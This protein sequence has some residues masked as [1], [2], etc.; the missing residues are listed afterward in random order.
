MPEPDVT[1]AGTASPKA[2]ATAK[3]APDAAAE[4]AAQ[5]AA[6]VAQ[7]AAKAAAEATAKAQADTALAKAIA[8]GVAH[9]L[10]QQQPGKDRPLGRTVATVEQLLEAKYAVNADGTP[11][12]PQQQL[13][14]DREIQ[15]RHQEDLLAAAQAGRMGAMGLAGISAQYPEMADVTSP[16]YRTVGTIIQ[17]DPAQL[18][19]ELLLIATKAA[20]H[21]LGVQPLSK[22]AG[23][24]EVKT[25]TDLVQKIQEAQAAGTLVK[26]TGGGGASAPA[27]PAYE[28]MTFKDIEAEVTR[29]RGY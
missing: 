6:Q 20:A 11:I 13:T 1:T 28:A 7:D 10:R 25:R 2:E 24:S 29:R 23:A 8:D 3:P 19:P 12:T 15:V 4:A 27:E 5:Q 18:P 16:L 26:G 9:G 21:D 14:I 22:R 17:G